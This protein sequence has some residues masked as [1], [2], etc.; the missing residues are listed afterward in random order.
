MHVLCL[1]ITSDP[2]HLAPVRRA[3]EAFCASCGFDEKAIADTGLCVNEALANITRHAYQGAPDKP[4]RL[5]AKFE[6][7]ELQI[8]LRDWGNGKDPSKVLPKRDPHTPGGI[9]LI[10]LRAL[11]DDI[12]FTRQPDG[13][14]LTMKRKLKGKSWT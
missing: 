13:M 6:D 2:I 10:C 7:D 5:D 4:V 9:G 12:K 14:L 8:T 3:V 1:E 11:M